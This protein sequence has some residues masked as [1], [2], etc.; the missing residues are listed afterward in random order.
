MGFEASDF[1]YDGEVNVIDVISLVQFLINGEF[2]NSLSQAAKVILSF[3]IM[4]RGGGSLIESDTQDK[5]F[6]FEINSKS[7]NII[8]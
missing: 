5:W 7:I 1:T 8:F 6:Q 2:D 3:C 4:M